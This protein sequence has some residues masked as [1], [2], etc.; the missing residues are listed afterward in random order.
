MPYIRNLV[1][2]AE[3]W[4]DGAE[5]YW[6]W[7]PVSKSIEL[8]TDCCGL[9]ADDRDLCTMCSFLREDIHQEILIPPEPFDLYEEYQ[10]LDETEA[11]EVK[12]YYK[13]IGVKTKIY[14]EP[15]IEMFDEES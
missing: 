4:A 15:P 1:C 10:Y 2:P 5:Q 13:S 11:W 8:Y 12:K 7:N 6:I 3:V 14:K 9:I